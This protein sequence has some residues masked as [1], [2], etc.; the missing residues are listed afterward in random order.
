MN[1]LETYNLWLKRATDPMIAQELRQ[2]SANDEH[3]KEQ[4]Y[5]SL[6]FG[7]GGLRG[8]LGAGT[9][10]MNIYTVAQA[11]Q[12]FSN[13]INKNF[14]SP[15][16]AIAYDS[17]IMSKEFSEITAA[18]F[19]A[20]GIKVYI[21]K[22]LAPTPMLSYAVRKLSCSGGVV[23]TA[24]HNP[25]IYNGY[26]A[27]NETGTQI[28]NEVADCI[29]ANI[30]ATD[31]FDGVKQ[32]PFEESVKS[33]Q[34]SYI[35][36]ALGEEYLSE[37]SKALYRQNLTENSDLSLVY[38]PL[39]GAGYR[40]ITQAIKGMGIKNLHVVDEQSKPNGNFPTCPYPNPESKDAL[41]LAIK[42]ME[43]KD[44]DL[45]IASD[46]DADRIGVAVKSNEG[47]KILTGDEVGILL[48][49]YQ[50]LSKKEIG[51]LPTKPVAIKSV[52]SS[53][54][55]D[56][57]AAAEGVHLQSVLTG[58]KNVGDHMDYLKESGEGEFIFAYEE[59]C[60]YLSHDKIRDKD[61]VN[62]AA[63]F[64]EMAAY[65]KENGSSV[66]EE[67]TKLYQ[68]FGYYFS[69]SL[70]YT[71]TG[72]SGEKIMA[73]LMTAMRAD[74]LPVFTG[75]KTHIFRDYSNDRVVKNGEVLSENLPETNMV[76][77][78]F[79]DTS[80]IMVRPSGTEPKLK[81][82][83]FTKGESRESALSLFEKLSESVQKIIDLHK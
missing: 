50:I 24:S 29:I 37:I 10:R 21:Y 79:E 83:Y 42:L 49:N 59:S 65:Y 31:I 63:L 52:V 46:P 13:Y 20:N 17:R 68:K 61:A 76:E 62:A 15:S 77:F 2:I 32:I 35:E 75:F 47:V 43:Q 7:T 54:M 11:T 74:K 18:V 44:A 23:V 22:E 82:Y 81:V 30:S 67:L 55:A 39:Y 9:N 48:L 26:K 80:S 8:I 16:V 38:T 25:S 1:Y 69:R 58:F 66:D 6:T 19:A 33:G 28:N 41:S 78:I 57:I 70:S 60:G 45:L 53:K 51:S 36:E 4:F 12:G 56:V 73:D 14:S 71:F 27:Y 40:W 34:I 64:A 5:K 3:I 72:I